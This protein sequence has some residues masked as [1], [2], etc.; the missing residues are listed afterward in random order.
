MQCGEQALL[1]AVREAE[2]DALVIANGFSCKTQ[3]EQAEVGRQAL[4]VGQ[5][6]KMALDHGV[7]GYAGGPPEE[8]YYEVRPSA[9]ARL[10]AARLGAIG[11][12]LAA[13]AGGVW[14]AVR[15]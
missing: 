7:T 1:P 9:P 3:I 6:I 15:R 12:G 5:V 4:H 8:P 14:L 10:R 11:A 13:V 2:P